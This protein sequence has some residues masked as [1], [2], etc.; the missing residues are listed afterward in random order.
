MPE[1]QTKVELSKRELQVLELVVTGLSNQEIAHQLVISPNT[2][3][4]HLR[5]IFGKL[6]VQSRTEATLRAIQEG[7][8]I[9]TDNEADTEEDVE[10]TPTR[11]YLLDHN[12]PAELPQWQQIYLLAAALLALFIAIIPL[13]TWEN[14]RITPS[15]PVI[16]NPAPTPAPP[17]ND[18]SGRWA[19]H[20]PVPTSRAG[21][22][23]VALNQKLFAI[24]GVKDNNT[25]TRFVEIYDLVTKKWTE[26]AN[27][28]TAAANIAGA[29]L[30]DKIYIPGG[31]THAGEAIASL[32]IYDPQA[33]KWTE[34]SSLPDARCAYGLATFED[35]LYLFGGWDGQDFSDSILSFSPE[36]KQWET[37]P[38]RLPQPMGYMGATTLNDRIYIVGGYNGGNEFDATFAFD[39]K[40]GE[41]E[42]KAS[43]NEKRGGLGLVSNGKNLFA[44]GGGWEHE[45]SSSEKYDPE[46]NTW[47]EFE[48]PST[49][50]WR[51]LGLTTINNALYAV[52]GW[53][54]TEEEFTDIVV[55]YQTKFEVFL[56]ISTK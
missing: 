35:K 46:T 10:L 27:K 20:A 44:V 43:L 24:G 3:K 15:I 42:Q 4:V 33:D 32:E 23:V 8:V 55:S 16:Y 30:D 17:S 1:S 49:N 56:P 37:L 21:L 29:I 19:N 34:G 52:G 45:L 40:S 31:C 50:Q 12:P 38:H 51:N 7:L 26:G 5:N 14:H 54:G 13:L 41:W 47:T 39:P 48:T 6:E 53:D 11:T 22:A 36:E 25:A 9:V 28:P 18:S 2:V